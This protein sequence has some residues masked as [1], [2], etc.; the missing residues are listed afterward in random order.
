MRKMTANAVFQVL[1]FPNIND[2]PF[3][4]MEIINAGRVWKFVD[5]FFGQ[6]RWK[7]LFPAALFQQLFYMRFGIVAEQVFEKAD[8]GIGI[9]ACAVSLLDKNSKMTAEISKA[10]AGCIGKHLSREPDGAKLGAIELK[11]RLGKMMF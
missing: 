1:G 3:L 5:L 6:V 2:L 10:V 7:R 4:V 8:R 11:A 9:T